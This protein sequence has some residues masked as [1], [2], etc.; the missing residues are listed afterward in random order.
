MTSSPKR[1][2]SGNRAKH[3]T[4]REMWRKAFVP[5]R[6]FECPPIRAPGERREPAAAV[7]FHKAAPVLRAVF[8]SHRIHSTRRSLTGSQAQHDIR[9]DIPGMSAIV[10]AVPTPWPQPSR[11][12]NTKRRCP[13]FS[14]NIFEVSHTP[15]LHPLLLFTLHSRLISWFSCMFHVLLFHSFHIL[16]SSH[17]VVFICPAC[18]R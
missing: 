12:K 7:P 13:A 1:R 18:L 15:L 3:E 4:A 5:V 9:A 14:E 11:A 6:L 10:A 8:A 16:Q 17:G 2:R